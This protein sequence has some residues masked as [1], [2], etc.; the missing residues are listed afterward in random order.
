MATATVPASTLYDAQSNVFAL[1][2][3]GGENHIQQSEV[4]AQLEVYMAQTQADEATKLSL[5][6]R[7][8][9]P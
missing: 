1:V 6:T 9:I 2:Q 5:T 7:K 8:A 3:R 4:W